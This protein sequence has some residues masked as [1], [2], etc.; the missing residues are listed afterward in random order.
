MLAEANLL[1]NANGVPFVRGVYPMLADNTC[2]FLAA[3]FDEGDWRRDVSAF[4][5]T[6]QRL[7]SPVVALS[8][9]DPKTELTPGLFSKNRYRRRRRRLGS[10]LITD[11][12]ERVPDIGFGSYRPP[13]R[14]ACRRNRPMVTI[15]TMSAE[16]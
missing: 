12:M 11:T 3:D 15:I 8:G 13:A 14:L 2:S 10:F 9:R 6:C 7:K 4:R 5:E 1:D 16:R